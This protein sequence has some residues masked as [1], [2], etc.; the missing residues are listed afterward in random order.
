[1]SAFR[2]RRRAAVR[3]IALAAA[4]MALWRP[5][6]YALDPALDISQYAHTAWRLNEGFAPN[7]IDVIG[8]TA[9]GY[10]WLGTDSGLLRFD[11]VRAN[12][13]QPPDGEPLP[14]NW[15]RALLGTRDGTL[16]IGTLAG[17]V[18]FKEGKRTSYP[19]L[20][21]LAISE[22]RESR[23]GTIWVAAQVVPVGG[24]IC[25]IRNGDAR[26]EGREEEFGAW[27]GAL[28]E[29]GDGSLWATSTKGLWRWSP[30]PGEFFPLPAGV[31]DSFQGL[32]PGD[33]GEI[34]LTSRDGVA[35]VVDGRL[36]NSVDTGLRESFD[37]VRL[38]RDRDGALWIGT[39]TSGLVHR[40][41]GRTDTLTRADGL[42]GDYV[43]RIFEDREGSIW[44]GT[45]DGLDRFRERA[46][47]MVGT[48]QGLANSGIASV[49]ASDDG[50]VWIS[51]NRGLH[52]W[53]GGRITGYRDPSQDSAPLAAA[54]PLESG[55][56]GRGGSLFED[57]LRRV[58]IGALDGVG[59]FDDGRFVRAHGV[60]AGIVDSFAEDRAGDLWIAHREQ[61]L[62]RLKDE[63]VI[64]KIPWAEINRSAAFGPESSV[65]RLAGDPQGGL[66]LGFRF[67]GVARF[68]EGQVREAYSVADGL[69]GGQVR[70]LRVAADG[71]VWA[72]T[73]GGLSRIEGGRIATLSSRN[74][75]PCDIVDWV[76]EDDADLVWLYMGCGLARIARTELDAW[77]EAAK[78]GEADALSVH[79]TVLTYSDGIRSSANLGS[80]SPH[81]AKTSD[82]R[83]W[84][85]TEGGVAVVDPANL[86]HNA[87]PPPVHVEQLVADRERYDVTHAAGP[88]PL[89]PIV[90]D[91]QID[92]TALS[93]A[94]PEKMQF[95]YRLEGRDADWQEAGTRRQAFY[96]G[97]PPGDYRFRVI[98]SNNDGVWNEEGA[99][100]AFTIASA[101][102]QTSWFATLCVAAA[103]GFLWLLY[104]LRVRQIE[105][106]MA[107][108][109][110]ERLAE[111][112]RIARDLHDTFLQSVQGLMLKFQAVTT[113]IPEGQP[114]RALLEEALDKADQVLA[115]GRDRVYELRA[116]T[117]TSQD[118]PDALAA[119]AAELTPAV[120]TRFGI[121]VEGDPR[122]LHP[123][124]REEVYRIGAE[125]LRN[126]FRHA[127][128]RHIDLE[129]E[130]SRQGL[131]LRITDDGR[132]F[133]VTS[134]T[135]GASGKHF[136]LTGLRER[137]KKIRAQ[138]EVSS[139]HRWG[140]EVEL[141]VPA[142]AAYAPDRR[143]K[144][145]PR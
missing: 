77:T 55:V 14:H 9:D 36:E 57:S 110:D 13:W 72:A 60:T 114:S 30:A 68:A 96:A 84:F 37:A 105:A 19:A 142:V 86:P 6:A 41:E 12:P 35:R 73:E 140:T 121:S 145:F 34:V 62:L 130:Y 4:L 46:I 40:H 104:V 115:E 109:L 27:V 15:I 23:D 143:T 99:S 29:D 5:H 89:P 70:Q 133:D 58:W 138:L 3:V 78:R 32:A 18:S 75:L 106:R 127:A 17:L 48:Q 139:R 122:P 47:S 66:W 85:S 107:M 93:L 16:W 82:G 136:G 103:A 44:V 39:R 1:M 49:L 45:T 131:L 31:G 101:F 69:G 102:Y 76:I 144:A 124:A 132:G 92:Y 25:V 83:L 95:R 53:N 125:A 33:R 26:C 10:L 128:A 87:M 56:P 126:A 137:A 141:R 74:G 91:L 61:G 54:E 112:G 135:A 119:V 71:A 113:A 63:Q 79:P 64:Q 67:G 81:G 94:A 52:R 88:V 100:V 90:R 59:Y 24:R 98:A 51:T 43:G 129:I 50:S 65:F 116:S 118:L 111:R 11:G 2:I 97:L 80:A 22:I 42:S 20:A 120:E 28:H 7:A 117:D 8:Q 134:L 21:G 123:V 108:R 38:L